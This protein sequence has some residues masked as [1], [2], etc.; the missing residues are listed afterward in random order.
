MKSNSIFGVWIIPN[1]FGTSGVSPNLWLCPSTILTVA[2]ILLVFND[3]Q[4]TISL[5]IPH[6]FSYTKAETAAL[7]LEES[8]A[9]LL[10]SNIRWLILINSCNKLRNYFVPKLLLLI[11]YDWK[12]NI[13]YLSIAN[14]IDYPYWLN[15]I[16]KW[17][18]K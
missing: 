11:W 4:L 9:T 18:E 10:S 15:W 8:H 12:L 13:E 6:S 1:K 7:W 2:L 14:K 3:R 5:C 17:F 16:H